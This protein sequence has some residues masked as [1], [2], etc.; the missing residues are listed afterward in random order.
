MY[1]PWM[2]LRVRIMR[3]E[4]MIWISPI[5]LIKIME[6]KALSECIIRAITIGAK[7][8]TLT[9]QQVLDSPVIQDSKNSKIRLS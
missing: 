4:I 3:I 5:R 6:W 7:I 8:C 2:L 1:S 9:G